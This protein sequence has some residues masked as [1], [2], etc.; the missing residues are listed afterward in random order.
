MTVSAP[1]RPSL[2]S[3][4]RNLPRFSVLGLL[5]VLVI[6]FGALRP[7]QFLSAAN[8]QTIIYAQSVP[9]VTLLAALAPLTVGDFDIS[10]GGVL[11]MTGVLFAAAAQAGV[12]LALAAAG[13]LAGGLLVGALNAFLVVRLRIDSFIS[14]LATA[15]LTSAVALFVSGGITLY[16]GVPDWYIAFGRSSIAGI[17]VLFI[18]AVLIAAALW[19]VIDLT[20]FGRGVRAAGINRGAADLI[21]VRTS[22]LRTIAFLTGALLAGVAGLLNV[23]KVGSADPTIGTTQAFS[24]Y[25]AIF[26]GA[27]FSVL[28]RLNVWGGLVALIT[29]SIGTTG[30]SMLGAPVWVPQALNGVALVVA[31]IAGRIRAGHRR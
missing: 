7:E 19:Y 4:V 9:L 22:R 23:A 3:W 25:S 16:A 13:A 27:T 6:V 17:P 10:I 14:T 2:P 18:I 24:A 31:L 30:L 21:G 15:T 26:L 11:G 1:V 29:L 8:A 12:P 28:G 20:P 5:L